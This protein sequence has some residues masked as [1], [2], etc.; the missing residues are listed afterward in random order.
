MTKSVTSNL[1]FG[2]YQCNGTNG[3]DAEQ[4]HLLPLVLLL[5]EWHP[6]RDQPYAGWG[7]HSPDICWQRPEQSQEMYD[8][9]KGK[10]RKEEALVQG[11][12]PN[13]NWGSEPQKMKGEP[14]LVKVAD[15]KS[16]GE[17]AEEKKKREEKR[18]EKEE[19]KKKKAD[20]AKGSARDKPKKDKKDDHKKRKCSSSSEIE[21]R[22]KKAARNEDELL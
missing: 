17:E 11:S 18:D 8:Y 14:R 4:E 13:P 2:F 1:G 12:P 21:K 5:F 6:E 20:D 16:S 10:E 22:A 9:V 15:V 19:K 7:G 3:A